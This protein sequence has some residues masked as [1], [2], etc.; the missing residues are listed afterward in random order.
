ML[1]DI[2][3]IIGLINA[4]YSLDDDILPI[5]RAR[6]NGKPRSWR[7]FVD[8]VQ[9]AKKANTAIKPKPPNGSYAPLEPDWPSRVGFYSRNHWLDEWG[10]R[11]RLPPE[12]QKLFDAADLEKSR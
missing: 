11:D 6:K 5:V 4:G 9:D 8:A 1:L 10:D 3:P 12:I 2:S 7:Y